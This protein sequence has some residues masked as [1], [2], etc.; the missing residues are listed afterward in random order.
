MKKLIYF[1]A[2]MCAFTITSC[3]DNEILE[4]IETKETSPD[5]QIVKIINGSQILSA[6]DAETRAE[7]GEYAL[8]FPSESVYISYINNLEGIDSKDI[9][10]KF[11]GTPFISLQKIALIADQELEDL[12]AIATSEE[13]F[14]Q[15]Y[16][17][18]KKKYEGILIRNPYDEE[19]L[20]LYVPDG[21][22]VST[23]LIN[24][25][26]TIIIG[27]EI[28]IIDLDNTLDHSHALLSTR[29]FDPTTYGNSIIVG[30]KK[31]TYRVRLNGAVEVH[32][33][34]QKKMWYGWKNDNN[35]SIYYNLDVSTDMFTYYLN[36]LSGS[37][38]YRPITGKIGMCKYENTGNDH[39][40]RIAGV[41]KIPYGGIS[42]TFHV[43]T[44][45]TCGSGIT[46]QTNSYDCYLNIFGTLY[47]PEL[48]TSSAYGGYFSISLV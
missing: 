5:F 46:T 27:N 8:Q 37:N 9:L 7:E 39:F 4:T 43:W 32:V 48:N 16:N 33:G 28:R 35:R 6:E 38:E 1:F 25:Q 30:S 36:P 20:Q 24:S 40:T 18:Y 45:Q 29:N 14:L 41:I 10:N 11:E 26:K 13:D 31:T 47:F 42:G 21:D 17:I 12:D 44:D 23:F 19:D 15:R 22:D 34:C 2:L 3:Q